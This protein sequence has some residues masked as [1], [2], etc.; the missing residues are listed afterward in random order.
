MFF[1]TREYSKRLERLQPVRSRYVLYYDSRRN[2]Q[3]VGC[4]PRKPRLWGSRHKLANPLTGK[5][6]GSRSPGV[7][8]I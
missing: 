6:E 8:I 2:S 7:Y 5:P 4:S 1:F 3:L